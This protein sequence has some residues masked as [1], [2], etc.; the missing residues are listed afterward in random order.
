[1]FG[2]SRDDGVEMASSMTASLVVFR[3]VDE[4]TG[5]SLARCDS[6]LHAAG[7]R[8]AEDSSNLLNSYCHLPF[9]YTL[10]VPA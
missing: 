9:T 7:A 5:R 1:M 6:L 4:S 2:S 3:L 8:T 10:H